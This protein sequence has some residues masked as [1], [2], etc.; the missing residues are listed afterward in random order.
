MKQCE[1][2]IQSLMP[3]PKGCPFKTANAF[4]NYSAMFD[5]TIDGIKDEGR[6]REFKALVRTRGQFPRAVQ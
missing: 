3:K 2:K 5:S 4:P 1:A 6:Y